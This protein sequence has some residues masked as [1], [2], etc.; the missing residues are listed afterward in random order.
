MNS[1][2]TLSMKFFSTILLSVLIGGTV[3]AFPPAPH[4]LIYGI[5]RDEQ[6]NPLDVEAE[7]I[8]ETNAGAV[9]SVGVFTGLRPG[10]N[11]EMPVPMDAGVTSDLY[12]PTAQR[13]FVPFV[14]R[15]R[16]GSTTYLP[17]EVSGEFKNLGEPG[18]ETRLDLTLGEDSD[19]DGLPD[20]WERAI[21]RN[22]EDVDPNADSDGDGMS[23]LEEYLAGSYAFDPEDGFR[24]EITGQSAT[25]PTLKFLAI[26]GR[27]Y[28]IQGSSDLVEWTSL[29]FSKVGEEDLQIALTATDTRNTEV[30]VDLS[31]SE[32]PPMYFRLVT[33]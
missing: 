31:G 11:Y 2:K 14:M 32:V 17:I 18:K 29:P 6:G 28:Q 20:A 7:V 27:S 13:P 21:S 23:N 12:K 9:R 10:V 5:V 24:V 30:N 19:G 16:I 22:L 15:V 8:M 25:G 3:N 26:R 33:Q 4:H 1:I